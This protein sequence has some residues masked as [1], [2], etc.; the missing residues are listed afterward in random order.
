MDLS[1]FPFDHD[2]TLAILLTNADGTVYHRYGGRSHVSP[3]DMDGLMDL[4]K[5]GMVTHQ[6]YQTKPLPP[7]TKKPLIVSALV[8][9][10]LFRKMKPVYGCYHCHHVREAQQSLSIKLEKWTPDQFWIWPDP[11]RLGLVMDQK[12][13]NR[14]SAVIKQSAA[15]LAGVKKGDVLLRLAG[16]NILTKYDVQWVLEKSPGSALTMDYEVSRGNKTLKGQLKLEEAWKVG[17]P[18]DYAWRVSNV[19]TRHMQKFLPTPGLIGDKLDARELM[20]RRLKAGDFAMKVT[21][22]NYGTH[23]AGLRL[24][25]VV[26][27]ASGRSD[28]KTTREFFHWCELQRRLGHDLELG[29]LRKEKK[30]RVMVGL[31]YL[32]FPS[33]ERSPEVV[34]GFT[35]QEVGWDTGLR[36]GNVR[37]GSSAERTGLKH[38]DGILQVDGKKILS[39]KAL[40]EHLNLK[41]PGDLLTLKVKRGGAEYDYAYVLTDKEE[42]KSDLAVLSKK[43]KKVGQQIT[44]VV[45]MNLKPGDHIYSVHKKGFGLPTKLEFRGAGYKLIGAIEEPV[46][47]KRGDAEQTMWIQE[48]S[49][50]FKQGIVVTDPEKFHLVMRA[51]AQVCD[52]QRCSELKAVITNRGNGIGFTEFRGDF[53][54][55]PEI[56][57]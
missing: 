12:K 45:S 50:L 51:Y 38:G 27:S 54:S 56:G 37:D 1:A 28:F 26:L 3:M 32:N 34:L 33:V 15:E 23:L 40:E 36:V 53:E 11:T 17:E 20:L 24:G 31:N 19:F 48:G 57:P 43:V 52:D 10:D 18:A 47:Q 7:Q 41:L 8:E 35:A 16:Q 30:M 22:L 13:Q 44:C 42:Q 46:P 14:V 2:L 4:L 9:R 39:Y 25:D 6:K 49:V 55:L 29:L 21:R 5:G